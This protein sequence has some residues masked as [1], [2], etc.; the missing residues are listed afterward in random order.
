MGIFVVEIGQTSTYPEV[1]LGLGA[2]AGPELELLLSP[3]V[4]IQIE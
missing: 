3:N 2:G 4:F 1:Y